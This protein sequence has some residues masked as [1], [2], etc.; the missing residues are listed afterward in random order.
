MDCTG[1]STDDLI[2]ILQNEALKQ[3]ATVYNFVQRHAGWA[4]VWFDETRCKTPVPDPKRYWQGGHPTM[5]ALAKQMRYEREA[6]QARM[7]EGLVVH[8]YYPD[9]RDM[10]EGELTRLLERDEE[11][12]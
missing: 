9:F 7:N 6:A 12:E 5:T 2:R 10:L 4:V 3:G 1:V 8:K 11:Q